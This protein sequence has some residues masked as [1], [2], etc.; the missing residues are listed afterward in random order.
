MELR[1]HAQILHGILV[2]GLLEVKCKSR[3]CG[4]ENG[5]IVL[6]RF[7]T[8]TGELVETLHFKDPIRPRRNHAAGHSVPL[9]SA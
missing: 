8:I 7:D 6:H 4:H 1:C 3:R 2:D 5:V 9:R